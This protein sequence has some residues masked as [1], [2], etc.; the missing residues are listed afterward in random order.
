MCP[1]YN[2]IEIDNFLI[3]KNMLFKST[4]VIIFVLCYGLC[5]HIPKD[6]PFRNRTIIKALAAYYQ[7][8]I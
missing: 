1:E 3:N 8:G 4:L 2:C 6:D 7:I 5:I